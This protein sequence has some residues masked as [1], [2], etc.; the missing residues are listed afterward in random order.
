MRCFVCIMSHTGYAF[1][2]LKRL[3]LFALTG[4]WF[5]KRCNEEARLA[6]PASAS[7]L[8]RLNALCV[9]PYIV[10]LYALFVASVVVIVVWI[11]PV[12]CCHP[13]VQ[14]MQTQLRFM[15]TYTLLGDVDASI[16]IDTSTKL[17]FCIQTDTHGALS[18][19]FNTEYMPILV[20][21][22]YYMID[23]ILF[24]QL[25]GGAPN[26]FYHKIIASLHKFLH[27]AW[28]SCLQY[29]C[30]VHAPCISFL[31]LYIHSYIHTCIH[32]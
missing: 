20:V 13:P 21:H 2:L 23:S 4:F 15:Y 31:R 32:K 1:Q 18:F 22:V 24:H 25:N 29:V 7:A 10:L 30:R 8:L 17:E 11:F 5:S 19:C 26:A 28:L 14:T 27:A 9:P 16:Y 12:S 3:E 6:Y